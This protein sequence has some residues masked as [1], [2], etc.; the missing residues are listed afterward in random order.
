MNAAV[1]LAA[2]QEFLEEKGTDVTGDAI[3]NGMLNVQWPG[4]LEVVRKDP[5]VVVNGAELMLKSIAKLG[6]A[7][8]D[9]FPSRKWLLSWGFLARKISMVSSVRCVSGQTAFR[10]R[11][12]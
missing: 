2:L 5:V 8:A 11:T 12:V 3:V 10:V 1:A 9:L 6:Q 4:R 7:V